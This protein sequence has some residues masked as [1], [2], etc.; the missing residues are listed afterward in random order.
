MTDLLPCPF[1]GREAENDLQQAY[2]SMQT[3]SIDHGAAVYCTGCNANMIMCR[4][5][6]PELS[7]EQRM[8]AMFEDWNRRATTPAPQ[9]HLRGDVDAA[10]AEIEKWDVGIVGR[11]FSVFRKDN[12]TCTEQRDHEKLEDCFADLKRRSMEAAIRAALATTEVQP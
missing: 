9:S 8:A 6:H 5:D 3:G 2:R 11:T 7:D 4:A 10:L 1:C 12:G